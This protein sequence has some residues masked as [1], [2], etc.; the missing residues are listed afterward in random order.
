MIQRFKTDPGFYNNAANMSATF[1]TCH[2]HKVYFVASISQQHFVP[3][4]N[5]KEIFLECQNQVY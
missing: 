4:D 5:L 2:Q 3:I 1:H